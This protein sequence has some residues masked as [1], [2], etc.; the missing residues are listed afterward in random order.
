MVMKAH[1]HWDWEAEVIKKHD[2]EKQFAPENGN[3]LKLKIGDRVKLAVNP[4]KIFI[5]TGLYKP[6]KMDSMYAR[7][8]R[9]LLNWDCYWFP[10]KESALVFV[11]E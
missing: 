8:Y 1:S 10:V 3:P 11:K 2:R 6:E 5:V 9:Y 4:T 7:G